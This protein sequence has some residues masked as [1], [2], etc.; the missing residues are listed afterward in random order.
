MAKHPTKR[1]I[2]ARVT[3]LRTGTLTRARANV[4]YIYNVDNYDDLELVSQYNELAKLTRKQ[5]R[6][7][8]W[9]NRQLSKCVA[10]DLNDDN[11]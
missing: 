11:S 1:Q 4:S 5:I 7:L 8:I 9:L 6:D 10:K 2:A 3:N